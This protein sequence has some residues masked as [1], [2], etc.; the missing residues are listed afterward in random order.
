MAYPSMAKV[1]IIIPVYNGVS[2]L[3]ASIDS[4]RKQTLS[5]LEI[6][7]VNDASTDG[8]KELIDDLA[9]KDNRVLAI[10]LQDNSGVHEARLAGLNASTAPFIG[11]LDADDLAHREMFET[12]VAEAEHSEADIVVCGSEIVN[13][14]G[15]V[16]E[17]KVTFSNSATVSERIFEKFCAF[18][19]GTGTLWNKLFKREVIAPYFKMHFAW[20]QNIN[21]DLLLNIGCFY[22]AKK[23]RLLKH[24]LHKYVTHAGGVTHAPNPGRAYVETIRAFALAVSSFQQ[25]DRNAMC[26]VIDMY[27]KQLSWRIYQLNSVQEL[28]GYEEQ[29]RQ[30][31]DTLYKLDSSAVGMLAARNPPE[32]VPIGFAIKSIRYRLKQRL[33][34]LLKKL[35]SF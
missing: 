16:L 23:V 8:S 29:I 25:F 2:R 32:Y 26:L 15:A 28:I 7:I 22:N 9:Q 4:L 12:M 27:R 10:H 33:L 1:S 31:V 13:D 18:E 34:L 30:A 24:M 21:E 5:D 14:D 6:I 35:S 17:P 19:F 3:E 11:F 20:R